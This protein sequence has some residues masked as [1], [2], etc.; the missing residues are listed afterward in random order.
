MATPAPAHFGPWTERDLLAL[1]QDGQRHEL[2]EGSLLVSPPPAGRHQWGAQRLVRLLNDVAPRYLGAVEA[3]G[4]RVPG[5]TVLVPDVLVAEK[6]A[7]WTS[8]GMLDAG[9]VRLVIEIVSPGSVT[10]DRLTK[11][12]LYAQARIPAFWRVELGEDGP[13][14]MAF[15]LRGGAYVGDGSARRGELLVVTNPFPVTVDP[16]GLEP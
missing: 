6:T 3:L 2:V 10:M 4:V 13:S 8:P 1:P 9:M 15:R 16:A 5:G 14:I 7:I 11:P 12:A